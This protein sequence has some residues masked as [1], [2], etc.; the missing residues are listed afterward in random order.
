[1]EAKTE[2]TADQRGGT[3][4]TE[5]KFAVEAPKI[6]LPK[7]GG[8][9]RGIG[10]KFS[11]NPVTGTASFTVPLY[12]SPGRSGFQPTL[13]MS[14]DSGAGNGPFGIGWR[15]SLPTITRKTEKGLPRYVDADESDTFILSE[16]EDLVPLLVR[17]G[18]TWQREAF[19]RSVYGLQYAVQRY[20]PRVDGLFSRIERWVNQSDPKDVFWRSI[21]KTNVTTWYG[22]TAESRIFDPADP[23]R[24]FSW[25]ICE[26]YDGKGNVV[27][28]RYKPEDG[29]GVDTSTANERNRSPVVRGANRYLKRVFYGNRTPYLPDLTASGPAALPTDWAFELVLDYGEH[30]DLAPIPQ[31]TAAPW[32]CRADAFSTYRATFEVRTYRLC[33]RALVFNHF[34]GELGVG[35]NC[36]VR[37]TEF[38][39]SAAVQPPP[40][41]TRPFYSFL[42]SMTQVGYRR[43][44]KGGYISKALPPLEFEYSEARI[45]D[46]VREADPASLANV[47][48]GLDGSRYQWVDLDGEGVSG[49]LSEQAG[50]WFYKPNLS[51]ANLRPE[52]GVDR[53]EA[54]FAPVETVSRH[55]SLANLSDGHQRLLDIVGDGHARLVD[56]SGP[57]PGFFERTGE[58]D[59]NGFTPFKALPELNWDDPN[60]KFIDLTG[61]GRSDVLISEETSFRWYRSLAAV[62]FDSA[63]IVPQ[64]RDEEQGPRLIFATGS[65]SLFLADLSGDG[66]TDLVRVRNG[67]CC[68]WP[69][70]G[71]GRFGAKVTMDGSPWFDAPEVFD[72]RRLRFTDVDGS[73]TAD[74]V[75]FASAGVQIY[76]NQSG[77]AWGDRIDI[78]R[79]PA[80][81]SLSRAMAID[82]LGN[83]TS[84]LV[85]SSPLEANVRRP[86]RYID[87]MG[88]HKPHLLVRVANNLGVET[89]IRYAP[90]TQF[91]IQ[92]KLA[93]TPWLTRIP[94][95]VQVV[96]R[97]DTYDYVSRNR[98]VSRYSYHHGYFDGV[99]REFR[100]F[101]RVD[102]W[103]TEEYATLAGT[104]SIPQATN[105]DAASH[106]PPMLTKTW[107]HTGV[108]VGGDRI[109]KLFEKEYYR[110][111]MSSPG[112]GGL[113]D[114]QFESILREDTILPTT[115]LQPNGARVAYGITTE[116][117]RQACRAL[118]G[119]ILRQETYAE[120][121]Q[122][123]SGRPYTV[124]ERN[125]TIEMLQP[126]GPN[127]F[128][129]FISHSR[130]KVDFQ[131]ERRMFT[132]TGGALVDPSTAPPGSVVAA[133]PRVS[134][135]LTL[136]VDQFGNEL[137]T[138]A[139]G[140]GRRFLDPSLDSTSQ[141][142]QSAV[143]GTYSESVYTNAVLADDAYRTPLV[144][145]ASK[146]ELLQFQP[147]ASQ[148]GLTGL[149]EFG[150]VVTK[151]QAASDGNHEVQFEDVNPAM[152]ASQ[153]YRRLIECTRTLY[154]PD[155]MGLAAGDVR[156]LLLI[157][158]LESLALAGSKYRLALTP[159]LLAHVFSRGGG[160]LIPAPAAVL[161]SVAADG[162]GYVD[163]DGDGR[164]WIASGRV[165]HSPV[166]GTPAQESLQARQ[167]YYLPRR[168]EDPFGNPTRVDY[169]LPHDLL[170]SST[171]DAANNA[172][173][174][175][176]DYRVLAPSQVTDP[177]GNRTAAAFD[178]LGQ[179]AGTAVM[180]KVSEQLGDL[181]TGFSPDL[182]GQQIDDFYGAADPH[183]LAAPLLGSATTCIVSDPNRFY[184]TRTATPND[185]TQWSPAF[186]ATIVRE[187]HMSDL[188]VAANQQSVLQISFSYADGFGRE[189]QKKVQAE[190][191]PL[192]DDGPVVSP[193]WVASGWTVFNNKGK[194]VRSYEP[195]FHRLPTTGH[196]F[197]FGVQAGVSPILCYDPAER[198]VA[199]THP[200]QAYEKVV[201]DPWHQ[202]TW[203]ANDTVLR[204]DPT[205]DVDV[206]DFF[207]RLPAADYTPTWY[208]QRVGGALG[209]AEQA[210]A[211]KTAAHAGTPSVAY[212][213]SLGRTIL[214][215][216][217]N[218]AAGKYATSVEL[219][220]KGNQISVTDAMLRKVVTYDYDMVSNRLH[221][222][223]MEAG[224]RWTLT[225]SSGKTI[226]H[227]DSRGHNFSTSYDALR[228]QLAVTVRGTDP[229]NSDPR[230]LN[231]DVIIESIEYGEGAVNDIALN[232][233]T[234]ILR[235]RDQAGVLTNVA[236][237][238][239]T[240]QDEAYDFKG[241]LLRSTR[242]FV[243][244]YK[245]LPDWSSPPAL[246]PEL[247]AASSTYDA[248]NRVM[249]ATAPDASTIQRAYNVANLLE[250]VDV[251]IQGAAP[252]PLITNVDYNARRQRL[253][254]A[255]GNN[256][257]TSYS[258]EPL[259]YRMSNLNT[260]RAGFPAGE[261]VVQ[262]LTYTYD[263][264]GNVTHI[265]DDA[266][267]QDVVYFR[268]RRVEPSADYTYDAVY[269]LTKA[270]GR[271]HLGQ[272]GSGQ[273]LPPTATTYDDWSRIGLL[274][275]GDGN[276]M[277]TYTETYQYDSVGN[278]AHLLHRGTDPANPG[279]SRDFQYI[280]TSL[281][282][283]GRFSNRLSRSVINSGLAPGQNEDYAYDVH[284]NTTQMPQLS[285]MSWDCKD[286]LNV[287]QRQSVNGSDQSGQVH[288]GERTYY[289]HDATGLRQRKA[290]DL[291]TGVTKNQ[292]LYLGPWEIYREYSGG[293]VSLERTTLHVMDDVRRFVLIETVTTDSNLPP[294]NLPS[295]T[296]RYQFGNH[297]E[298]SVL[299]LDDNAAVVSYEE[300]Y[301]YGGT[302]Y[303]ALSNLAEAPK[304][305]RFTAKERDEESGLYY[306]HHRFYAPWI[307]RWTSCDP[308]GVTD[309]PN[310][311]IYGRGS[312]IRLVDPS[313][314]QSEDAPD[315]QPAAQPTQDSHV[316]DQF[317]SRFAGALGDF[318]LRLADPDPPNFTPNWLHP[319]PASLGSLPPPWLIPPPTTAPLKSTPGLQVKPPSWLGFPH[320]QVD[321]PGLRLTGEAG[322]TSANLVLT[323]SRS[324]P[325]NVFG[326]T[327]TRLSFTYN[328]G[329]DL[330]L[331][332]RGA[333]GGFSLAYNPSTQVGTFGF[334]Q[335]YP[336][337]V[338]LTESFT[339]Q[340]LTT[341]GV[342][343]SLLRARSSGP[344]LETPFGPYSAF[345][346]LVRATPGGPG[347]EPQNFGDPF[348]AGWAGATAV[349]RDF[350]NIW[351]P[352]DFLSRHASAQPGQRE[353]DFTGLGRAYDATKAI[354]DIPRPTPLDVRLGPEFQ[355]GPQIGWRA[356][357]NLQVV[358][359]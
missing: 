213:D 93:G 161:G 330:Q 352:L 266:D 277:G 54:Q 353:S 245:L 23:R 301:P 351:P 101:G 334:E 86:M 265:Q 157:G 9:I 133:D 316:A 274:H 332:L 24:I 275:P 313:G 319:N 224:E 214:T 267:I 253:L 342:N 202:E 115:I 10:E 102:Q 15:L 13:T 240:N 304:R 132:V 1:M 349:G 16:A 299:E 53:P 205:A 69:N 73:G 333:E 106:V 338:R 219:D 348:R 81:E 173:V 118:R 322:L 191:G 83:G 358:G 122:E 305:Y 273:P 307:A 89:R 193:R 137:K 216:V 164:W 242:Q 296:Q 280:E 162:G 166:P 206:G 223:S 38:A 100:G 88:G 40:D 182:S 181:L 196:Q 37:A 212:F 189:I 200:N 165:F 142:R 155:D 72:A 197:E 292:R 325:Y 131:Y 282:E 109:S 152:V 138:I 68:Y 347:I 318:K 143:I 94:F 80:V 112:S 302:S 295:T 211:T 291:Q 226:R 111:G 237:S 247:L 98:F 78:D 357:I 188:N 31:D 96:E 308:S 249:I 262:D 354:L 85:W 153:P 311:Y 179:V 260:I 11:A 268:N 121:G 324:D 119:S 129:I 70:L 297:L 14:Y 283:P 235:H 74:I 7:G 248:L 123:D 246:A 257:T 238:P 110:E 218:A 126:Q 259:T 284:G 76:L 168:Y 229:N 310:I 345:T 99:E 104:T 51:P 293:V 317:A 82:L 198:V 136:E 120:D 288:Q 134:H 228:R 359:F 264:S 84:C 285:S 34:E 21:S 343:W 177:N 59:W 309:G 344:G 150:E 8:A 303:Q 255:F 356:M 58:A 60:L 236:R 252:I 278:L 230:T 180:G 103:D 135:A 130:E 243:A 140:Y 241:N 105:L 167:H 139:V 222:V 149:F 75:Y 176:N 30:D 156:Q 25:L 36:L 294:A 154:R 346:P 208:S 44:G 199:T 17:G 145:E 203:D 290:T 12:V 77:N 20:R 41:P 271:E 128:A 63:E 108:F 300:Y 320:F 175:V 341:L 335:T 355:A 190:P 220:I 215:V 315:A 148:P 35:L 221:R 56:F 147:A 113:G 232:L 183:T 210:A 160:A 114:A 39:H 250:R 4:Q 116:E 67:E 217:D 55:P 49:I 18:G 350:P 281:V 42:L 79:F 125:Y 339:T 2:R 97:V 151:V 204:T 329:R 26:S 65:E 289:V 159:G 234:R 269:R 48:M 19:T 227:W 163:L 117:A 186:V 22:K 29:T 244:D 141:V 184:R 286:Q 326:P 171:V 270:S 32:T 66:L 107:F 43:D 47:P 62:G 276:A 321:R 287:T 50:A 254:V 336:A 251:G 71:Y 195:F 298:S 178:A 314:T 33:H 46:A 233:R 87:L 258:Y 90:S 28:Y 61:A 263:P 209:L 144:A 340:G 45:D 207:K 127:Q 261:S 272:N 91:Y 27:S 57:T 52:N 328:Y 279:W 201:F 92:D 187:T 192:V 312:P 170:V 225:D 331:R 194:P 95:P 64:Q 337:G 323:E 172:V 306:H 174:A 6:T 231:K 124:S 256:T 327:L 3:L 158:G 5:Q 146:Y 169:E 239:V 185:P